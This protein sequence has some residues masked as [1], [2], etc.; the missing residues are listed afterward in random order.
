LFFD[1]GVLQF[2]GIDWGL[3]FL[4]FTATGQDFYI[5]TRPATLNGVD[6]IIFVADSQI[7]YLE[8]NINSWKELNILFEKDFYDIP[9]IIALNK[10]DLDNKYKFNIDKFKRS[11]EFDKFK[12]IFLIETVAINGEGILNSFKHLINFLFP[13]TNLE[14]SLST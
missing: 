12:N 14:L 9:V 1:F 8:S 13:E 2:K 6:G 11:I 4:V 5:G 10:S 7:Q 3:K